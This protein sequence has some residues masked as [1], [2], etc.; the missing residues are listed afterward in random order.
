MSID[1]NCVFVTIFFRNILSNY[2]ITYLFC[3]TCFFFLNCL[4]LLNYSF[5]LLQLNELN[6]E[7][8]IIYFYNLNTL[9]RLSLNF[10]LF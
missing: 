6:I 3:A 7:A 1:D 2:E 9:N 4:W 5:F 10:I 8:K